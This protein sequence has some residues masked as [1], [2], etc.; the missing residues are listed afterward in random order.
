V[1]ARADGGDTD[2]Q[3]LDM[4]A[5][6]GGKAAL[7]GSLVPV[8]ARLL[9]ADLQVH[10]AGLVA[11]VASPGTAVVV[12]DGRRGP[13]RPGAFDRVLVDA[14]CTGL[15]ALRR[16]PEVRWRRTPAD[17][18]RLR[19]LQVELLDA[20]V[21]AARPGGLV[22][23][24]TCSPHPAETVQV[25]AE[26]RGRRPDLTELDVRPLLPGLP[27]LGDGPHVQLWT[28]RHETDAMFVS[29]LRTGLSPGGPAL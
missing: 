28:H 27:G 11:S 5:G 21:Q 1:L 14:P 10:R 2:R 19:P 9:A 15:G 24:V 25:V 29:L 18:T 16:R 3:W 17:V 8:G 23:Y 7:L 4:C 12:A 13:W 20:A 6:P 22:A 26:V